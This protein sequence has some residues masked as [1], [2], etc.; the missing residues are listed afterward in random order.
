MGCD[1][2]SIPKRSELVKT[3]AKESTGVEDPTLALYDKYSQC[4]VSGNPLQPANGSTSGDMLG[5]LYDRVSLVETC[6]IR[7]KEA[8]TSTV[9]SATHAE[10]STAAALPGLDATV[11]VSLTA[12]PSHSPSAG[13][14]SASLHFPFICPL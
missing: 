1:G 11:V 7:T 4:H 8:S 6:L 14:T 13:S 10:N 12:N 9:P 2:G 3:A 5:R